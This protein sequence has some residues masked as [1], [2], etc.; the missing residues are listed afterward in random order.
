MMRGTYILKP[1]PIRL[2]AT[3]LGILGLLL[4]GPAAASNPAYMET[5]CFGEE[6]ETPL[7]SVHHEV[8]NTDTGKAVFEGMR[9]V[10]KVDQWSPVLIYHLVTG[11]LCRDPVKIN[12]YAGE[13]KNQLLWQV[14]FDDV[15]IGNRKEWMADG[16]PIE[17][18]R[19]ELIR[20]VTWTYFDDGQITE[21][22]CWDFDAVQSC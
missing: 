18:L 6:T 1:T 7:Q 14:Q 10:R 3:M 13:E 19:F 21:E 16:K 4:I 11:K 12:V 22:Y 17:A 9:V 2:T 5:E 20:E 8:D 15:I